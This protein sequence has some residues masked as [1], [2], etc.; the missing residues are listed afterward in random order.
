MFIFFKK[1]RVVKS[2]NGK[3]AKKGWIQKAKGTTKD[4]GF[5]EFGESNKEIENRENKKPTC[6]S[7]ELNNSQDTKETS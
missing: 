6:P 5:F 2:K 3:S 1:M 4:I 7:V